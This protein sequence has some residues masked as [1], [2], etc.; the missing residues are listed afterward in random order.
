MARSNLLYNNAPSY[1]AG[2]FEDAFDLNDAQIA[3]LDSKVEDFFSWHRQHELPRYQ[4]FL[5]ASADSIADGITAAEFLD[6]SDGLRHAWE[7]SMA[8]AF[9]DFAEILASLT[10]AQIDHYEVYF[11]DGFR[12]VR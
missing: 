2:K 7:R 5:D 4:Q 12:G 11:R 8:R 6:I 10:P 3:L 9:D 1:L